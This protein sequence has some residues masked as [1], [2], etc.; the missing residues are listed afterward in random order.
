[1]CYLEQSK[2][3][4]NP[5]SFFAH[6]NRSLENSLSALPFYQALTWKAF[7]VQFSKIKELIIRAFLLQMGQSMVRSKV[8][9]SAKNIKNYQLDTKI[10]IPCTDMTLAPPTRQSYVYFGILK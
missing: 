2:V 8:L 6:K 9:K 5:E 1:M 7:Y 10:D 3:F 4:E